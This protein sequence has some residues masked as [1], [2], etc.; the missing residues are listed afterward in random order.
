MAI[1]CRLVRLSWGE[2]DTSAPRVFPRNPTVGGWPIVL[3][4]FVW[5]YLSTFGARPAAAAVRGL[6]AD[7]S[8]KLHRR[9][10]HVGNVENLVWLCL[11]LNSCLGHA[12]MFPTPVYLIITNR[13]ADVLTVFPMGAAFSLTWVYLF[14]LF[15]SHI[16]FVSEIILCSFLLI[17]MSRSYEH[18]L[19]RA[20]WHMITHRKCFVRVDRCKWCIARTLQLVSDI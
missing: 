11:C 8:S 10:G 20:P 6:A 16:T 14:F 5:F 17:V 2:G 7:S 18:W 9:S 15:A 4:F 12:V 3:G 19:V 13:W 1:A